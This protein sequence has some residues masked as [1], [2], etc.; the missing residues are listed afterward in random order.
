MAEFIRYAGRRGPIDVR[1]QGDENARYWRVDYA[2]A[3]WLYAD[4]SDATRRAVREMQAEIPD[5][6]SEVA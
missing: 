4:R 2:G 1:R 3:T 5:D 6:E